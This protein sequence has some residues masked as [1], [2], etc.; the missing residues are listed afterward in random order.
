MSR[1]IV[2]GITLV[3]IIAVVGIILLAIFP[4]ARVVTRDISIVILAV[5]QM[6]GAILTIALLLV[7]LYV[8]TT[9]NRLARTQ[10]IPQVNMIQ[11]KLDGILENTRSITGNVQDTT[12]TV[13]TTTTY[14]AEQVVTPVIRA[15][16]LLAGVRAAAGSLARRGGASP[17]DEAP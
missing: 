17:Q 15:S 6:I 1:W 5:F 3:A 16:S 14:V 7:V 8:V 4:E 12:T 9:L 13:T 10:V 2:I 11:N